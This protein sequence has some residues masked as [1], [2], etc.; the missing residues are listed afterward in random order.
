M[1]KGINEINSIYLLKLRDSSLKEVVK[2]L[3]IYKY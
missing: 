2:N 3:V 1:G